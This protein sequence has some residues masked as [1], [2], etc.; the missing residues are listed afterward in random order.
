MFD[1][2]LDCINW[3]KKRNTGKKTSANHTQF[4][5]DVARST[6]NQLCF[7]KVFIEIAI[8]R[9]MVILNLKKNMTFYFEKCLSNFKITIGGISIYSCDVVTSRILL[10]RYKWVVTVCNFST[11]RCFT[12]WNS[13]SMSQIVIATTYIT[14]IKNSFSFVTAK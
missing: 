12:M 14:T 9:N 7:L 3:N 11:S 13:N 1:I 6:C 2:W 4:F 5:A 8:D 10:P